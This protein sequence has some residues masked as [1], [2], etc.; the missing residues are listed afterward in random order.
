MDFLNDKLKLHGTD[1]FT[2]VDAF[3]KI[4]ACTKAV[5]VDVSCMMVLSMIGPPKD[6][7]QTCTLL[8]EDAALTVKD[9]QL[10]VDAPIYKIKIPENYSNP[11]GQPF[12]CS[13]KITDGMSLADP[14]IFFT[15]RTSFKRI[16]QYVGIS[17]PERGFLFDL[18]VAQAMAD[19]VAEK[20]VW[21]IVRQDEGMKKVMTLCRKE[22]TTQFI[23][24]DDVISAVR[25]LMSVTGKP[26]QVTDWH[27]EQR[28]RGVTFD[29][30]GDTLSFEWSDCNFRAPYII[31]NGVEKRTK[32]MTL[33]KDVLEAF[34]LFDYEDVV[35]EEI[36]E[37]R[38][39]KPVMPKKEILE[40]PVMPENKPKAYVKVKVV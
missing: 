1:R 27:I 37:I 35:K 21:L 3:R 2:A 36:S 28:T 38:E 16:L 29:V 18:K 17:N 6:G 5:P 14:G 15:N 7:Y 23:L 40:M 32:K 13:T 10:V 31:V 4:E 11:K 24:Y 25:K 33:E 22:S 30:A 19:M 26:F 8:S 39:E 20:T 9:G 12:L 34:G